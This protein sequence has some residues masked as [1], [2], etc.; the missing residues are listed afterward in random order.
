MKQFIVDRHTTPNT[1]K[2][3]QVPT[4]KIPVYDDLDAV[5]ADLANLAVGQLGTT[6]DTG[7]ELS[8]PVDVVEEGN[9]HAVSSDAVHKILFPDYAHGN[10]FTTSAPTVTLTEDC[11][12]VY[13]V[14]ASDNINRNL[15]I[16]GVEVSVTDSSNSIYVTMFS[17][18]AKKGDVLERANSQS[19]LPTVLKL[20]RLIES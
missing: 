1:P 15:V 9:L 19:L 12:I 17:G 2:L 10:I 14:I 3:E 7:T 20:F 6:K 18:F 11:Y 5:T 4:E 16:N 8:Q 13:C